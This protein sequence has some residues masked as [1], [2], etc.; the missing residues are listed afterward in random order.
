MAIS[1]ATFENACE[2]IVSS[3]DAN[4]FNAARLWLTK[5]KIYAKA[6]PKSYTVA[7]KSKTITEDLADLDAAIDTAERAASGAGQTRLIGVAFAGAR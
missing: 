1:P 3:I 5:A 2:Q 7:G 6:L 4:D